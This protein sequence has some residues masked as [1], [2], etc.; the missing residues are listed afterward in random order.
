[1]GIDYLNQKGVEVF[2]QKSKMIISREDEI[3]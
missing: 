2:H 1:M 3:I